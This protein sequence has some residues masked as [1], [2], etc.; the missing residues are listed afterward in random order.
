R[1][2]LLTDTSVVTADGLGLPHERDL[3]RATPEPAAGRPTSRDEAM[4]QRLLTALDQ[5]GGNISQTAAFLGL[6]RSNVYAQLDKYGLRAE[7]LR[8]PAANTAG[9]A[10]PVTAP[11]APDTGLH[12][13]RRSLT[14]LRAELSNTDGIDT[15][16]QP[17]RA[18][19]AIIAKVHSFGGRIE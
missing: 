5:T 18:L 6:A 1:A 17:S 10:E 7:P 9:A 2:A 14:L 11:A 13:E 4:R 3:E 8:T 19:D 15:W 12:W 16:S